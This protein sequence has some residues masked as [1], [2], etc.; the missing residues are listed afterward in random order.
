MNTLLST[1]DSQ[2]LIAVVH[3][4]GSQFESTTYPG[5]IDQLTKSADTGGKPQKPTVAVA[6]ITR[7]Q[8]PPLSKPSLTLTPT[9]PH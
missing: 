9:S 4:A 1:L 5:L 3:Q 8:A 6:S 2:N 7:R